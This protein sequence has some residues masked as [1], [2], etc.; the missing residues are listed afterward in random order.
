MKKANGFNPDEFFVI[1]DTVR[2]FF[3]DLPARGE[4]YVRD[5]DEPVER[6]AAE[7]PETGKEFQRR[8]HGELP[9]NWK[10]LIPSSFPEKPT[11]SRVS[12]GQVFNP[13]AKE[14]PTELQTSRPPST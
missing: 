7:Y 4:G 9:A 1:G 2:N 5:W 11:P 10:Y 8:V 3:H 14:I 12:S 13:I 6:Y